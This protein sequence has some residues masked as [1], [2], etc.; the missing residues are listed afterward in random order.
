MGFDFCLIKTLLEN[1]SSPEIK[2]YQVIKLII[3]SLTHYQLIVIIL[4]DRNIV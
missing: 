1:V 3:Y 2:N 4:I